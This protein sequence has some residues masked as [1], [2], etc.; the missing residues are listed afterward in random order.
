MYGEHIATCL[1]CGKRWRVGDCVPVLCEECY[2]AGHRGTGF[3]DCPLCALEYQ[4]RRKQ[5]EE[6]IKTKKEL[7]DA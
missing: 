4:E 3:I 5:I 6:E 7:L 1:H 2:T